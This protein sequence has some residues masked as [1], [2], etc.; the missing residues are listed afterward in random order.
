MEVEVRHTKLNSAPNYV[1]YFLFEFLFMCVI[2]YASNWQF[3][4]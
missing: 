1:N 2:Y 3:D 4:A